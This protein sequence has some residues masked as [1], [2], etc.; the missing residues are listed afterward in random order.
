MLFNSSENLFEPFYTNKDKLGKLNTYIKTENINDI[1]FF[2]EYAGKLN[3]FSTIN[4]DELIDRTEGFSNRVKEF[5]AQNPKL[6]FEKSALKHNQLVTLKGINPSTGI[7]AEFVSLKDKKLTLTVK[8]LCDFPIKINNLNYQKKKVITAPENSD[9]MLKYQKDTITF[10]L[11]RSFENLFVNK[12]TKT[13]GFVFEKNIFELMISYHIYGLD[14]QHYTEIIPYQPTENYNKSEDLFRTKSNLKNTQYL[15]VNNS[16]KTIVI[17]SDFTLK[18]PLIFPEN[19]TIKT[20]PGVTINIIEGGKII[21]YSPFQF[22]GTKEQ[23]I[24]IISKDKEGQGLLVLA[25]GRK[26]KLK[27]VE[28]DWLTN[29]SHGMWST[30]SAVTFYES[31][32]D[33]DYVK[34]SN[35][36]CEDAINVVRGDFKMTNTMFL[37]TQSDAFDGDFVTGTI[38]S[39]VFKNLGN[40][41]IDVSGSN[42]NIYNVKILDAGDKA[43]SAG[44]NSQMK[45]EKVDVTNCEIA[46]AGKD[47]SIVTAKNLN[48][49]NTKLGFTAFQKKPEFGPSNITISNIKMDSVE[50]KYLIENT[51]SLMVDGKKIETKQADVKSVMYGVEFGV[52]SD[53]TRNRKKN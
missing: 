47:L 5:H 53:E 42:L 27:Y 13:T 50:T 1:G 9:V 37:N 19:Y 35:N 22:I 21:S 24:R 40:D 4:I 15:T 16:E 44:E 36:T 20:K 31:P 41:A 32:V 11:P 25:E 23:P 10:N 33:F 46:V 34:I 45:I 6:L 26:S 29:P 7:K 30:T 49:K 8:N 17:H 18:T 3:Y 2:E 48:I 52:S 14:K 12:K 43:L 51:S 39:C 38:S 28:F